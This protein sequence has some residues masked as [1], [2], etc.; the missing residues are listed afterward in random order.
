M[1]KEGIIFIT[2]LA[3]IF[4]ITITYLLRIWSKEL[5]QKT[6]KQEK[7]ETTTMIK[8]YEQAMAIH[9]KSFFYL[10]IF[11]ILAGFIF[12]LLNTCFMYFGEEK[13]GYPYVTFIT[14]TIISILA[15][16]YL[17]V[18]FFIKTKKL[19]QE[20]REDILKQM[21]LETI[22]KIENSNLRDYMY[23]YFLKDN[24]GKK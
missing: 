5:T 24:I 21:P 7:Q 15:G 1:S 19:Y 23:L 9:Y 2:I 3:M 16:I 11:S 12:I 17:L 22:G 4:V 10:G 20:L 8:Y 18:L 14:V 6:E 13:K